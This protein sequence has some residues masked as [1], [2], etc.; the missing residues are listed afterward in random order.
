ME[1]ANNTRTGL[2]GSILCIRNMFPGE[3]TSAVFL[4]AVIIVA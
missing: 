1:S 4:E 2:F 3:F